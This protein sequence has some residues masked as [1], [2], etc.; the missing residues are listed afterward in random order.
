MC[1]RDR[2]HP[3]PVDQIT[4]DHYLNVVLKTGQANAYS[5]S[6]FSHAAVI[7]KAKDTTIQDFVLKEG[8]VIQKP[9]S[10]T[11]QVIAIPLDSQDHG[12]PQQRNDCPGLVSGKRSF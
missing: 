4:P 1:I 6:I 12:L 7:F 11:D 3:A 8:S 2:Y 10:T 9:G 5:F